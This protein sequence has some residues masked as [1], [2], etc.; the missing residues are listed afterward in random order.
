MNE[1]GNTE[2]NIERTMVRP[3]QLVWYVIGLILSFMAVAPLFWLGSM[4]IK[5]NGEVFRQNLFPSHPTLYNVL[6]VFTQIY[7]FRYLWNTFFVSATVT[8][9]ALFFHSMA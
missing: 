4:G 9:D 3:T 2:R 5:K 1:A 7:F 6:Y 8:I